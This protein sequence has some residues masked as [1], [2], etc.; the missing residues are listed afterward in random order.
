MQITYLGDFE[1]RTTTFSAVHG[2]SLKN[3]GK[4]SASEN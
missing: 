3:N 4:M 2:R 1:A